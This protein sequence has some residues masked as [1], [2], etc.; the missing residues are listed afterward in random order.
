VR[1]KV[2][3]EPASEP[4]TLAEA[5]SHLRINTGDDDTYIN[6]LIKSARQYVEDT[7]LGRSLIT[8]TRDA[9]LDEFPTDRFIE[10]PGPIL[11]SVTSVKYTDS[12]GVEATMSAADYLVDT[13]SEPGRIV[14]K[15]DEIWPSF[16]P[17]VANAVTIR[18]VCGYGD[19][20]VDVPEP[21]RQAILILIGHQYES[22]E[23]FIVGN[24]IQK[25]SF[26]TD[27]LLADFRINGFGS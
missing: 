23:L 10:L 2:T 26:S 1:Y 18:Y 21:I 5:C 9:Y 27:A 25:V 17:E 16:T 24:I 4:V 12:D 8:Q 7:I 19:T 15:T 22:R 14:L 6:R 20:E 11:Q 3:T 13:V